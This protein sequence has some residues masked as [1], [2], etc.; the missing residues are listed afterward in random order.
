[1]TRWQDG[2]VKDILQA[3][4]RLVIAADPDGLL[5]DEGIQQEIR[6][7]RFDFI[8]YEDPAVFRYEYELKYRTKWDADMDTGSRVLLR[9]TGRNLDNLPYDLLQAGHRVEL[10]LGK[11]FQGLSYPV[12]EKL[13]PAYIDKLNEAYAGFKHSALGEGE[14]CDFILQHVFQIMPELIKEPEDLLKTLLRIHY[15]KEEMPPVLCQR[16]VANLQQKAA[17]K[18]WPLNILFRDRDAFFQFLQERWP[19]FVDRITNDNPT[20]REQRPDYKFN[21]AGPRDLPFEHKDVH[22]YMDNLFLEG[23]LQPIRHE[24]TGKKLLRSYKWARTGLVT[25]ANTEEIDN[26]EMMLDNLEDAI[27]T[28]EARYLDWLNFAAK[29]AHLNMLRYSIFGLADS[30]LEN[31]T[32]DY[33]AV[34]DQAFDRWLSGHYA[35][36][37]N[38]PP[39]PPIMLHHIPRAM[40]QARLEQDCRVALLVIDGMSYDQWLVIKNI[41][42][43]KV[44]DIKLHE[45]AV[46]AWAPTITSIS[47]QALFAGKIPSNFASSIMTTAKEPVLWEQFWLQQGMSKEAIAYI[48]GLGEASSLAGV[49]EAVSSQ[50]A[51]VL[52]LVVDKLDK[53]MHG[54]ELGASGMQ[55]QVKQWANEGFLEKLMRILVENRFQI[56]LTS[57]HGNI[58][59]KGC[60]R[61]M[62]GAIADMKGERVRIY[63]ESVLRASV[64]GKF[65][66]SIEWPSVGLPDDFLPLIATG[67]SAFILERHRT[68]THGGTCIEE[69]IVPLVQVDRR[70]N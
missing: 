35:G 33:Q 31:R 52:G 15:E 65:P 24:T 1:M 60:G 49:E 29:W 58:E 59:A 2:I 43:Q 5:A 54:I 56:Y 14:T 45:S 36:L 11:L 20:S 51:K 17:F 6:T 69:L 57:D 55:G 47:R 70:T 10:N 34:I 37:Y 64:A 12:I 67:R 30:A 25:G 68:V 32:T 53:I 7:R 42:L 26:L 9:T 38:M 44:P 41:L 18:S 28:A 13:P 4:A 3:G 39:V 63:N 48:K 23:L 16:L 22:I 21:V 62:E 27:P 61:P 40:A 8:N 46:F 50:G 19:L 66:G